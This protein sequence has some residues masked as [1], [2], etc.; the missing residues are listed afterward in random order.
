MI[1]APQ[2]GL[3]MTRLTWK[4]PLKINSAERYSLNL[5]RDTP[6]DL[7]RSVG[8][9]WLNGDSMTNFGVMTPEGSNISASNIELFN[10]VISCTLSGAMVAGFYEI[11]FTMQT[12][13]RSDHQAVR[14]KVSGSV[15][16]NR[17][18]EW[19]GILNCSTIIG[20]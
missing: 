10:G 16:G 15:E 1:N 11:I 8:F 17:S 13:R 4:K 20:C 14:L 7:D 9:N 19:S 12:D 18:Q 6:P 2:Q 3:L 5:N